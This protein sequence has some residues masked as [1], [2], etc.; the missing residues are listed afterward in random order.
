M[1]KCNFQPYREE[2]Q[3]L[4][5]YKHLTLV[6]V[7]L[8]RSSRAFLKKKNIVRND[9]M[10]LSFMQKVKQY[11][12]IEPALIFMIIPFYLTSTL[13]KNFELDKVC[14]SDLLLSPSLCASITNHDLNCTD[15][16]LKV[17]KNLSTVE[18]SW[19]PY[20]NVSDSSHSD[21]NFTVCKAGSETDK[22]S[23]GYYGIRDPIGEIITIKKYD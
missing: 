9:K 21:Y 1:I 19:E 16:L 6:L 2:N 7:L 23:A 11:L 13:N 17:N 12:T 15:E 18:F 3:A 4:T 22:I 5:N 14:R 8:S 20:K 10:N